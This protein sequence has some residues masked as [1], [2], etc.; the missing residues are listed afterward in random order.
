MTSKANNPVETQLQHRID[1][2]TDDLQRLRRRQRYV[3]LGRLLVALVLLV[4]ISG[5]WSDP[6]QGFWW[7]LLGAGAGIFVALVIW[8]HRLAALL[9]HCR[10][11]VILNQESLARVKRDFSMLL[12]CPANLAGFFS[13]QD[14]D[15]NLYGH[16]SLGQLLFNLSTS[17][18]DNRLA[19]WLSRGSPLSILEHHQQA[20]RELAPQLELRQRLYAY[21]RNQQHTAGHRLEQ[22]RTWAA[23]TEESLVKPAMQRVG[24]L[25]NVIFITCLLLAVS[26]L[27]SIWTLA[28]PFLL[29]LV[30]L[31][32]NARRFRH[33]FEQADLQSEALNSLSRMVELIGGCEF[34]SQPLQQIR[35]SLLQ[36]PQRPGPALCKLAT[37]VHHSRLRFNPVPYLLLQFC[38][39]WDFHV[40]L[41]LQQWRSQ[42]AAHVADWLDA[43]SHFEAISA[44][45]NL[46]FE[47]PTWGF[48]V[49]SNDSGVSARQAVHPLLPPGIAVANDV[50]LVP[51]QVTII[52]GSNMSG[53]TTYMR[54]LGLNLKLAMA[55]GAV[56]CAEMRFPPCELYTAISS[57]DSL[58]QGISYFMSEVLQIKDVLT[59]VEQSYLQPVFLL[60]EL[61]KGT[62]ERERNLAIVALLKKLCTQRAMGLMTTHNIALA[63]HPEL[64]SCC[65]TIYFEEE[66]DEQLPEKVVFNYHLKEGVSTQT[67]ALKLLRMLGVNLDD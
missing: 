39:L 28:L 38:V 1:A 8:H 10:T 14:R 46:S 49:C 2:F 29:N 48:P 31:G 15:L 19:E 4:P 16:A 18:G 26:Q 58:E 67:N 12:P 65:K 47:N 57:R 35:E 3:E 32:L 59:K 5:L 33:G 9:Q 7:G 13:E 21:A 60:D 62:N 36:S 53:K 44:L 50:V 40:A 52:T 63:T 23:D 17:L 42:Y 55:G 56:A 41:K 54:T 30:F 22:F 34:Q 37:I 27:L 25:L 43:I 45:A 51:G 61:L 64:R 6:E 24:W 20:V 11:L 66:I